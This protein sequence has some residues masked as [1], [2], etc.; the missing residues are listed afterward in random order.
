MAFLGDPQ[1]Y[2]SK[3]DWA[4]YERAI[5]AFT[6]SREYRI[7]GTYT[8]GRMP[9]CKVCG[10]QFLAS[11]LPDVCA[12]CLPGYRKKME[13]ADRLAKKLDKQIRPEAYG[14]QGPAWSEEQDLSMANLMAEMNARLDAK[15]SE[16]RLRHA[17]ITNVFKAA[18]ALAAALETFE[19]LDA[20]S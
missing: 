18:A 20:Y 4:R 9:T 8:T 15:S 7:T 12:G 1:H 3:D 2:M 16:E 19:E 6:A 17:K 11:A 14:S 10:S 13:A 5:A